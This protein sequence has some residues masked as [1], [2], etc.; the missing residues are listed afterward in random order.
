MSQVGE[1]G[2]DVNCVWKQVPSHTAGRQSPKRRLLLRRTQPFA[3]FLHT[4]PELFVAQQHLF[5]S[6][7]TVNDG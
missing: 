5:H 6:F 1:R 2:L 4:A 7:E 3:E